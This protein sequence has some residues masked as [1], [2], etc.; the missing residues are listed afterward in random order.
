MLED[1]TEKKTAVE[2]EKTEKIDSNVFRLSPQKTLV[3][4]LQQDQ[5]TSLEADRL[6]TESDL[7]LYIEGNILYNELDEQTWKIT[8]S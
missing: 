6:L 5:I 1:K 2:T 7:P 8:D 4:I 3:D